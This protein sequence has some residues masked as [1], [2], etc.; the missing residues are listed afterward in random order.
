MINQDRIVPITATDLLSMYSVM[1]AVAGEQLVA[2]DAADTQGDFSID[3]AAGSEKS[4]VATEPATTLNFATGVTADTVYFVPS[5]DYKGI[6]VGGAA[7]TPTGDT[8]QPD[9]RTLYLA[10]LS[11]GSVTITRQGM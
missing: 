9:G 10:A 6:K 8:V 2:V 3:A 5:Y 11:N 1:L 4:H 7:V